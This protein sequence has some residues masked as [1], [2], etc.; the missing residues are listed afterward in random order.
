MRNWDHKRSLG[1]WII[2]L[3]CKGK[4]QLRPEGFYMKHSSIKWAQMFSY[5]L[6]QSSSTCIGD[7]KLK[8][9]GETTLLPLTMILQKQ[10]FL[11]EKSSRPKGT[12]AWKDK[13]RIDN[14]HF[15]KWGQLCLTTLLAYWTSYN[16][17]SFESIIVAVNK[18]NPNSCSANN[19]FHRLTWPR[20]GSV[21]GNQQWTRSQFSCP[22]SPQ[23]YDRF[24]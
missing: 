21:W 15:F 24:R 17:P 23:P 1:I 10:I 8:R 5:R 22:S 14:F 7:T 12:S 2:N 19:H 3:P 6:T 4:I 11:M 20:R 13:T 16:K 18:E 9:V